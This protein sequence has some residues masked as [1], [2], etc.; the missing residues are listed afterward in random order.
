M[1]ELK[2][3]LGKQIKELREIK[4]FSQEAIALTIGI[5]QQAFQKI[6]SNAT[7]ISLRKADQ[8]AKSMEVELEYL[9]K[10][11]PSNYLRLS[12]DNLASEKLKS[13][14][15]N[16]LIEQLRNQIEM[17]EKELEYYQNLNARLLSLLE[18][19]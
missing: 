8:I 17:M 6:E 5:S 2:L 18:A 11:Q 4:G 15:L 14:H 3:N 16:N 19:K 7:K 9:L 10:F 1:N 12:V 13:V